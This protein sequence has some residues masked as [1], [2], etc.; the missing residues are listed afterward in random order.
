M[1]AKGG[2]PGTPGSFKIQ[3]TSKYYCLGWEQRRAM[4]FYLQGGEESGVLCPSW[5]AC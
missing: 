1:P 2:P 5:P 3:S 4:L